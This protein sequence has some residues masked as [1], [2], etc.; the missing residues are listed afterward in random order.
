MK[1]EAKIAGSFRLTFCVDI[2][3]FLKCKSS[4]TKR[5]TKR[6]RDLRFLFYMKMEAKIEDSF[7]LTFHVDI[8]LF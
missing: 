7:R 3:L 4:E 5:S 8:N 1:V 6:I 2:N